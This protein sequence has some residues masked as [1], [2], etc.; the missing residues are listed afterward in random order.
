MDVG[1]VIAFL[2]LAGSIVGSAIG[3]GWKMG[4]LCRRVTDLERVV[5]PNGHRFPECAVH[6]EQIQE[7]KQ[8]VA[9]LRHA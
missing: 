5:R 4:D 3:V 6:D 9:E 8:D 2:G 7:L 1:T